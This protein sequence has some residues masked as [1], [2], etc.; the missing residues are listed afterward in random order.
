MKLPYGK[1]PSCV[2][3]YNI[4][5]TESCFY[6]YLPI[7][8]QNS[9]V[10]RVPKRLRPLMPLINRVFWDMKHEDTFFGLAVYLTVKHGI[11]T[12]GNPGNRPGYHSDGFMTNDL[13][14]IWCD[15]NPTIFNYSDFNLTQDEYI[16]MAEMGAQALPEN[17]MRYPS[18]SL[19]RL[20]QFNI[21]KVA[22]VSEIMTRTFV[23]ISVSKDNYNLIGN[24]HNYELKYDWEMK[25]RGIE[26][27]VPQK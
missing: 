12:P 24:S 15:C 1:L 27:N 23:K 14:Y 3:Q 13:N 2:G 16:S 22:P 19:L 5:F 20:D 9:D 18:F 10:V 4:V 8:L 7:K 6:L 11:V 25:Q 21:H 17:E 26:R